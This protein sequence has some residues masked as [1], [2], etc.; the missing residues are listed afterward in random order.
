M[1]LSTLQMIVLVTA[2]AGLASVLA[3]ASLS[4]TLLAKIVNNMVSLS[5]GILLATAFL[6]SY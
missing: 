4:L 1:G 3:A 5:V 6:H 2:G